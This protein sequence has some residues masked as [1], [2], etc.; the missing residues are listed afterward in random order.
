MKEFNKWFKALPSNLRG[1]VIGSVVVELIF[2]ALVGGAIV[3]VGSRIGELQKPARALL[4]PQQVPYIKKIIPPKTETKSEPTNEEKVLVT[5]VIDGDTIEIEGGKK[6]R[7]IGIDCPEKDKPF[8]R[9][10]TSTNK[11]LVEGRVVTLVKD[12]SNKDNFG[13]LLRYVYVSDVFVNA[14]LVEEGLAEATPYPPDLAHEDEFKELEE[15]AKDASK[16]MWIPSSQ[17]SQPQGTI[18][19]NWQGQQ[20][21]MVYVNEP[22]MQYHLLGCERLGPNSTGISLDVAKT[23]G[24]V[25]CDL[26]NPPP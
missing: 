25:S 16:G 7:Y 11:R 2:F 6:V 24:F 26:C 19:P 15:K 20:Q 12:V 23:R 13:R 8:S 17:P 3:S 22:G 9:E 4:S 5:R 10:A 14:K 21:V 18:S 1:L